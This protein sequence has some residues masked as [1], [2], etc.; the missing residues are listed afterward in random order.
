MAKIT[1]V[2]RQLSSLKIDQIYSVAKGDYK[3]FKKASVEYAKLALNNFDDALKVKS[4]Q[5]KVPLFS[6]AGLKM[7]KIWFL[8]KL[9]TKT[10]EEKALKK[11][12]KEYKLKKQISELMNSVK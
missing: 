10:P 4:P 3:G 11:M 2:M 9:R 8:N 12:A 7:A 5:F 1:P 6:S